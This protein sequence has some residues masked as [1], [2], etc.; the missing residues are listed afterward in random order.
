MS[1]STGSINLTN[2]SVT[3]TNSNGNIM[4][5]GANVVEWWEA[6]DQIAVVFDEGNAFKIIIIGRRGEFYVTI[7]TNAIPSQMFCNNDYWRIGFNNVYYTYELVRYELKLLSIIVC[8]EVY[9][10]GYMNSESSV[11]GTIGNES[12]EHLE[13]LLKL[14]NY[15]CKKARRIDWVVNTWHS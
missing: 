2:T 15:V 12:N 7:S 6:K 13:L 10:N 3:I 1:Y 9:A 11:Q 4:F 5:S 8:P 14:A